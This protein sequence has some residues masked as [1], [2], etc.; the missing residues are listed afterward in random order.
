M[1]EMVLPRQQRIVAA[2]KTSLRDIPANFAIANYILMGSFSL[3][4]LGCLITMLGIAVLILIQTPLIPANLVA[5]D[6]GV[7]IWIMLL[8]SFLVALGLFLSSSILD[9]AETVAMTAFL[10][11]GVFLYG[12]NSVS[13]QALSTFMWLV[14]IYYIFRTLVAEPLLTWMQNQAVKGQA[15]IEAEEKAQ[16]E[17]LELDRLTVLHTLYPDRRLSLNMLKSESDV[18]DLRDLDLWPLVKVTRS[19]KERFYE[20]TTYGKKAIQKGLE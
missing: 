18:A 9:L 4:V 12:Q 16:Q 15:Q 2:L 8:I 10:A 19:G 13:N 5:V 11:A 3:A 20:L 7:F 14:S 17:R 6:L 1:S